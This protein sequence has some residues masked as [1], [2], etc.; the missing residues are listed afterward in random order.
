MQGAW[1]PSVVWELY[2]TCHEVQPKVKMGVH[3]RWQKELHGLFEK[4]L[5]QLQ[6]QLSVSEDGYI[7]YGDKVMLVSPDHPETEADLFLRGDL[8]LCM[9]PDEIKAHL[10]NELEVPCGLSATQTKIPVGR[11]TFTILW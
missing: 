5:F 11:N 6:M 8:S 1:V 10:S 7:H 2:P 9:T 4:L 3:L